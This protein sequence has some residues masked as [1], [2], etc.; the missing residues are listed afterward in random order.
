[1]SRTSTPTSVPPGSRVRTTVRPRSA[2]HSSS[3]ADCVV[4]PTP[5]PPSNVTN[6]P[7]S[8]SR[9]AASAVTS[10]PAPCGSWCESPAWGQAPW[11]A[12]RRAAGRRAAKSTAST[13]SPARDRRVRLAVGHV[14]AEAA[15]LD[16]DRLAADGVRL[17]L[18]E[19]ARGAACAV[20]GLGVHG[21]RLVERDVEEL[22]LALQRPGV[23]ALLEVRTVPAVLGRDLVRR[24]RGRHP[25]RAAGRG[26]SAR[27]RGRSSR[28][29]ST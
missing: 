17:E 13:V 20:F 25:R 6:R 15:V 4:L 9:D 28:P 27:S 5:S 21:Q 22:V 11:R 18:L 24:S 7:E 1:M 23:G 14:R 10:S 8:S 19:R 26:V 29:T 12:C 3:S 2:S 16:L